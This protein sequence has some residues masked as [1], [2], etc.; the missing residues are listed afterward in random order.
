MGLTLQAAAERDD[1]ALFQSSQLHYLGVVRIP[2]SAI[3][4]G[5]AWLDN[6]RTISRHK[7]TKLKKIF[8]KEGCRRWDAKNH[9]SALVDDSVFHEALRR[10]AVDASSIRS[11]GTGT[12]PKLEL[13]SGIQVYCLQ[14]R[15]RIAAATEFLNGDDCWWTVKL[16]QLGTLCNNHDD[17]LDG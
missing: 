2:L 13:N 10:S 16:F 5:R 4:H 9:I 15:H 6:Q 3:A 14:G 11:N 12:I 1:Q 7:V 8:N 17:E